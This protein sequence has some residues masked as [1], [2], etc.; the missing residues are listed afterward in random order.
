MLPEAGSAEYSAQLGQVLARL[1]CF[2]RF[3]MKNKKLPSWANPPW[4]PPAWWVCWPGSVRAGHTAGQRSVGWPY[5]RG[6]AFLGPAG[7]WL[8]STDGR[9]G[10]PGWKIPLPVLSGAGSA[11]QCHPVAE[12]NPIDAQTTKPLHRDAHK[13]HRN[14][15][16]NLNLIPK[17]PESK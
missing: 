6:N 8:S 7:G 11:P 15:Y 17:T 4:V 16:E 2:E 1:V 9:M 12:K 13:P 5:Q 3:C 10:P 14:A